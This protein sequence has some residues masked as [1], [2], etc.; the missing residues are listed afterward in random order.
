V[1]VDAGATVVVVEDGCVVGLTVEVLVD[2][3]VVS[4]APSDVV[5]VVDP[6]P[7]TVVVEERGVVEHAP[8][9][10]PR[11]AANATRVLVLRRQRTEVLRPAGFRS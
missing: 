2:E 9:A 1:V 5:L 8:S 3:P 7:C 10:T 11:T 4:G 6:V